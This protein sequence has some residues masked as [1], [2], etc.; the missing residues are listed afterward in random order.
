VQ[1]LVMGIAAAKPVRQAWLRPG[2]LYEIGHQA[3]DTNRG[4][5][6]AGRLGAAGD[7][8]RP[9]GLARFR[10]CAR[11]NCPLFCVLLKGQEVR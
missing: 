9:A 7:S 10:V 2:D 3:N 4:W 11:G 1:R 8:F 6:A 5:C